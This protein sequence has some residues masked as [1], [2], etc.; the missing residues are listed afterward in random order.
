LWHV[1]TC[2]V[3]WVTYIYILYIT[4]GNVGTENLL[5]IGTFQSR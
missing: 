3:I 2:F 4:V 1:L 5:R